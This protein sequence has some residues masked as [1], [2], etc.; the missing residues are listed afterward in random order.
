MAV[1]VKGLGRL[2]AKLQ[3]I[4]PLTRLGASLGV[5]KAAAMVEGAAKNIVPVDS[6]DLKRSISSSG[7]TTLEGA[8]GSVGTNLEYAPHV[9][10]GTTRMQAQPYL[11]PALQKNK[12]KARKIVIE[13]I[14]KAYKGL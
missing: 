7:K 10:F 12:R 11:H 5:A 14:R 9:E 8:E 13:E 2:E 1:R 3:K 6:G 4:D